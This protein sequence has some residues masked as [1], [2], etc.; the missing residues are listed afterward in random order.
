MQLFFC[1]HCSNAVHFDND[2]CLNCGRRQGYLQ[3]EFQMVTLE[4]NGDTWVAPARNN[5]S[6][7]FCINAEHGVCN[8][9]LPDT[10]HDAFCE[11]CRHNLTI[12]DLTAADNVMRWRKIELAKRYVFRSLMRW[13]L[14]MPDRMEDPNE[15][16]AFEFLSDVTKIDGEIEMVKTGHDAGLIT[17]NIAEADD[18]ERERRRIAMGESYR[19][20]VGHFRHELAHY[21]WD[22]LVRDDFAMLERCRNVF[23]DER[24]DYEAA[25]RQ[26][27]EN[28]PPVGWRNSFITSYATSHPWEDFAETWAHYIHMVDALE[29]A[30]SYGINVR[31]TGRSATFLD[32]SADFEPYFAANAEVLVDAWIPL[33]V[34]VNGVNRSMGQP[35]LYPF[36]LSQPVIAKLQFVHELIHSRAG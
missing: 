11:A 10:G 26:H 32:Q 12:P 3:T 7:I 19:T 29:T 6:F 16:L 35:D 14:P 4:R 9:L 1:Q 22:R 2:V 5:Q 8:W 24:Q 13:R 18:A 23:G 21:F 28:G 36:V 15:G 33:T 20:L 30:R 17:L 34:A 31:S 25:L 27:Y